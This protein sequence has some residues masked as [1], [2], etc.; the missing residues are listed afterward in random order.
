[1]AS[2]RRNMLEKNIKREGNRGDAFLEPYMQGLGGSE[3]VTKL[4]RSLTASPLLQDNRHIS[5]QF[6]IID[7]KSSRGSIHQSRLSSL[8]LSS[9]IRNG[10]GQS[11]PSTADS[12]DMSY[13]YNLKPSLKMISRNR[14]GPTDPEEEIG[15]ENRGGVY[16]LN[17]LVLDE[18]MCIHC[19]V[20]HPRFVSGGNGP[21]A[22]P[23]IL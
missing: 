11:P 22:S 23:P 6:K 15:C 7:I 9:L 14:F 13:I 10:I 1:M 19:V 16:D 8:V 4:P 20:R 18:L 3:E 17:F 5:T 12:R 2:N 21:E